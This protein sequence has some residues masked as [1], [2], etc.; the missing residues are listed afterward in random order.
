MFGL[1][2]AL[3]LL[4]VGY[5][6]LADVVGGLTGT[7]R[8]VGY[9]VLLI[10]AALDPMRTPLT[11]LAT[12]ESLRDTAEGASGIVTVVDTG[13]DLQL[14]LDNYY[15]LGGSAAEKGQRRQG[16][17]PLL[18]H[19]AP[20]RVAFIGMATGISASAAPALGVA[21]T[22]VI[23]LVPEVAAMAARYF[24]TWNARLLEQGGVRLV[25]DDGRRH[26]AAPDSA[27][28]VI[29][30]DLF[31]PWHAAAGSLYSREMYAT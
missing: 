17:V 10:I 20:R 23:E 19:P 26:L 11:H 4:A 25:V 16:L 18:L 31:I 2:V 22:T 13:D 14:R 12:G 6:V 1:R 21:E 27:F 28:D 24:A 9:A 5:V 29:V 7:L 15:V 8:V 3:L 30:S